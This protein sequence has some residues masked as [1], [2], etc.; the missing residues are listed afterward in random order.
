VIVKWSDMHGLSF[1]IRW[2]WVLGQKRF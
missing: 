2:T 1:Y